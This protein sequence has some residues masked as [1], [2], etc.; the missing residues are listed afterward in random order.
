MQPKIIYLISNLKTS[1]NVYSQIY[2]T[3]TSIWMV[4][5][6]QFSMGFS[7]FILVGCG[8]EETQ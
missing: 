4:Q 7:D 6:H 1:P 3:N 2:I 5:D 8:T